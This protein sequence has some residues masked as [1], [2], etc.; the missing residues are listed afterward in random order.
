MTTAKHPVD[1]AKK[2]AGRHEHTLKKDIVFR[3][4]E[5]KAGEKVSLREDQVARLKESGHI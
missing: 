5:V 1:T 4:V 2:Q 3:G